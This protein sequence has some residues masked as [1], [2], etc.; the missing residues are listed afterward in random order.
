MREFRCEY[1]DQKAGLGVK[2]AGGCQNYGPFFGPYS[3]TA[4]NIL[5]T[6]T[7]DHNFDNHPYNPDIYPIII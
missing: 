2:L 3:K 7:K 6:Q 1:L 5:G 4:P